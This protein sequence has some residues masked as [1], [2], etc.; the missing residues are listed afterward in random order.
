MKILTLLVNNNTFSLLFYSQSNYYF[1]NLKTLVV[2]CLTNKISS[3]EK[4]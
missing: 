3:Y 1:L 4:V 2:N